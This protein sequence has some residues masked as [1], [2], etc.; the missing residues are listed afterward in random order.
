MK[1][2]ISSPSILFKS[3]DVKAVHNNAG[4]FF[5]RNQQYGWRSA[6]IDHS[7]F[8][9]ISGQKN[10]VYTS[11]HLVLKEEPAKPILEEVNQVS[12]D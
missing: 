8:G 2:S 11:T 4:L 12:P 9:I 6:E 5:G 1:I 3:L 10:C 7:G